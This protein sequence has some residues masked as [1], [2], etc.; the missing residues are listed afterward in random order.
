[1]GS[2]WANRPRSDADV[3]R[4]IDAQILASLPV[5][6]NKLSRMVVSTKYDTQLNLTYLK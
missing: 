5:Y 3:T 1:M 4:E 2:R 6:S